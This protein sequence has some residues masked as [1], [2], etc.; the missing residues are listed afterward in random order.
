MIK[1]KVSEKE[2]LSL[3]SNLKEEIIKIL[4]QNFEEATIETSPDI[5]AEI[6][7]TENEDKNLCISLCTSA[8]H[9]AISAC[10]KIPNTIAQNFC[11]KVAQA[12][13]EACRSKCEE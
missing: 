7:I 5:K 12:A 13:G 1:L 10:Y 8:E 4:N 9:A 6:S 11:I 3:P 2:W